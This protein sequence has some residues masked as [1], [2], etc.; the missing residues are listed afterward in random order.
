ME[1][2]VLTALQFVRQA[3]LDR[4]RI[5]GQ[6]VHVEERV[7]VRAQQQT[8]R[9]WIRVRA[10]VRRDVRRLERWTGVT[11]LPPYTSTSPCL[12]CGCPLR[13]AT[14]R[15][16]KSR[17]SSDEIAMERCC[18]KCALQRQVAAGGGMS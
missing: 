9:E 7:D 10:T 3:D 13:C 4:R 11:D 5:H 14:A 17:W 16:T 18:S 12:N 8:V 15:W 2:A 1:T 6:V